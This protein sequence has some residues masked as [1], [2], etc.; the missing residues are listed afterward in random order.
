MKNAIAILC[1]LV[2]S[3]AAQAQSFTE[4]VKRSINKVVTVTNITKDNKVH[5]GTGFVVHK[6][7]V[8]ITCCHL[9]KNTDFIITS[10][11]DGKYY[12]AKLLWSNQQDDLAVLKIDSDESFEFFE[13]KQ[14]P[15]ELGQDV[16]L[17]GN[18]NGY[19]FTVIKGSVS[20]LAREVNI[21]SDG[22]RVRNAIQINAA[23]WSGNSGGPLI[24]MDGYAVGMFF[25]YNYGVNCMGFCL[26]N[27]NIFKHA[28]SN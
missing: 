1:L 17:I 24:D 14:A 26:P 3:V 21:H 28:K 16:F 15:P 7:G 11:K 2:M 6:S 10:F 5:K 20:G 13:L 27:E 12:P 8:V 19:T 9:V 4:T 25:S 18:T 22:I 23:I